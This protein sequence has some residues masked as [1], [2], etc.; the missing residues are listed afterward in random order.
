M[1]NHSRILVFVIFALLLTFLSM[2]EHS[3][4]SI[5][6]SLASVG[7]KR[8]DN[9]QMQG[10]YGSSGLSGYITRKSGAEPGDTYFYSETF[11]EPN[12]AAFL[13]YLLGLGAIIF[14]RKKSEK[15]QE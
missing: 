7:L 1:P 5:N 10:T 14:V 4:S 3:N 13:L 11:Y 8:S 6:K 12:Y 9:Q 15:N 2:G